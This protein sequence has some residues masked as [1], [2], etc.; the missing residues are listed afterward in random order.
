MA[1]PP[2]RSFHQ[3][4][5]RVSPSQAAAIARLWPRY[6]IDVGAGRLDLGAVFGDGRP[7]VVE[8][9]FGTGEATAAMAAADPGTNLLAVDVH[10]PGFGRLL[11]RIGDEGLEHVRVVSGDAVELLRDML[12]PGSLAGIR[13]YFPDPWPKARHHKRRLVRPDFA[14]LA[15]SRLTSAGTLHLATDWPPYAEAIRQVLGRQPLLANV[16]DQQEPRPRHRPSGRPTTRFE[17]A[18]LT[19]GHPVVD[20]VYVRS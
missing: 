17:Q 14:S 2:I 1:Q 6:G 3:R 9:G 5:G 20:L 13:I 18:G 7:V 16:F 10:T 15:V 12:A 19:K 11:Q 4:R 8:I